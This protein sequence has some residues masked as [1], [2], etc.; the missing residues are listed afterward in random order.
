MVSKAHLRA[1]R[2]YDKR[3]PEATAY[4]RARN[5]AIRF[6]DPVGKLA[7]AVQTIDTAKRRQDLEELQDRVTA[8]LAVLDAEEKQPKK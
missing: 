6:V 2:A 3:H 5:M 1:N 8:A 4:H 7:E